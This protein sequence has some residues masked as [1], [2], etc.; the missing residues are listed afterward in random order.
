MRFTLGL[1]GFVFFIVSLS[2]TSKDDLI[3][4]RVE[5]ERRI[6]QLDIEQN[7]FVR[8]QSSRTVSE[9][10]DLLPDSWE[11]VKIFIPFS[12]VGEIRHSSLVFSPKFVGHVHSYPVSRCYYNFYKAGLKDLEFWLRFIGLGYNMDIPKNF[13]LIFKRIHGQE[14][15]EGKKK[16]NVFCQES[17]YSDI[18]IWNRAERFIEGKLQWGWCP[19]L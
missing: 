2:L 11:E 15:V 10:L 18:V 1:L 16:L 13:T 4:K 14:E 19:I 5:L 12:A 17:G 7:G 8:L 9:I 3:A 6:L